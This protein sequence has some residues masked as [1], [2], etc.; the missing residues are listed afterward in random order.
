MRAG[1]NVT[2]STGTCSAARC[3]LRKSSNCCCRAASEATLWL[4][5]QQ[6]SEGEDMPGST[7]EPVW[8]W[9]TG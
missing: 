9:R 7:V 5:E 1:R 8:K 4:A 6:R 3:R 2:N